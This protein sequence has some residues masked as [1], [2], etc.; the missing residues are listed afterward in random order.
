[1]TYVSQGWVCWR[2]LVTFN[3][4]WLF[5]VT[6]LVEVFVARV[7]GGGKVTIPRLR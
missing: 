4:L 3:C 5:L 2:N 7:F 1:M 6:G